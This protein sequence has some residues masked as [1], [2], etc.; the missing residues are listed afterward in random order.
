[1]LLSE[2]IKYM[3][4]LTDTFFSKRPFLGYNWFHNYNYKQYKLY[5]TEYRS[6]KR[7]N[8]ASIP[9]RRKKIAL[10]VQKMTLVV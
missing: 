10:V 9:P 7:Q 4:L 8:H 3:H 1:M 5:N 6:E 2:Q